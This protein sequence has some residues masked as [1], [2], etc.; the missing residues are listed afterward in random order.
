[1][2]LLLGLFEQSWAP[3]EILNEVS[4]LFPRVLIDSEDVSGKNTFYKLV[5][6]YIDA[7][8]LPTI[9][10]KHFAEMSNSLL[11]SSSSSSSSSLLLVQLIVTQLLMK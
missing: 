4:C 9:R 6:K 8:F 11:S 2:K 5:V 7:Q 1:M 3:L 10:A